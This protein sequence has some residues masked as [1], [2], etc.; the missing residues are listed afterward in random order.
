MPRRDFDPIGNF[1]F[2]VEISGVDV[3]GFSEVS[4]LEVETEVIEYRLGNDAAGHV[5]KIPG[6]HKVSDITLKRGVTGSSALWDWRRTVLDGSYDR[7]DVSI[8]LLDDLREEV[9]RWN[10]FEAWPSKYTGPTLKG[11]GNEVAIE[12]LVIVCERIELG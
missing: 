5:R 1:N 2:R 12:T 6:L 9:M 3:A 4:G 10:L 11:T 8:I 7:R